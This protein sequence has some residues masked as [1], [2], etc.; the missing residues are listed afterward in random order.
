MTVYYKNFYHFQKLYKK[1][2][3]KNIK[4]K[5]HIL[6][7]NVQFISKYIKIKLNEK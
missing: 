7:N 4:L 6:G 5:N 2:Y 1:A 3:N